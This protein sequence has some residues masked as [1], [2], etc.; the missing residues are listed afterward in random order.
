MSTTATR[1]VMMVVAAIAVT[2]A[3]TSATV[4]AAAAT[5]FTA[6]AVDQSLYFAVGGFTL[7]YYRSHKVQC[8]ACQRMVQVYLHICIGHIEHLA[9]ESVAIFVLQWHNGILENMLMV[10]MTVDRKDAAVQIQNTL[11]L[12]IAIGFILGQ[13]KVES[14]ALLDRKS[15]V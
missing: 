14:A 10:E 11:G 5:A 8:L 3:T 12:H 6:Q 4:T 13:R 7:L 15:V 2:V 1:V 9:I